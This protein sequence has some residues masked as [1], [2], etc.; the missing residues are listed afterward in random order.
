MR[1]EKGALMALLAFLP[2]YLRI[3]AFVLRRRAA[4]QRSPYESVSRLV[5]E[6]LLH[7]APK[8]RLREGAMSFILSFPFNST[9][10]PVR[11]SLTDSKTSCLQKSQ[12]P[13][14]ER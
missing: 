7:D 4:A 1:W 11:H 3:S 14:R 13:K 9:S 5:R 2:A 8:R 12:L 10:S 6:E